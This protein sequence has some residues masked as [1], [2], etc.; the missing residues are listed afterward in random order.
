MRRR[1]PYCN[2]Q[3][4]ERNVKIAPI[5]CRETSTI[6]TISGIAQVRLHRTIPMRATGNAPAAG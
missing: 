5:K 1:D 2:A 3:S 6:K 4:F